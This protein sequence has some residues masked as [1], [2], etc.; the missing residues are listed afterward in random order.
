MLNF[1]YTFLCNSLYSNTQITPKTLNN[2]KIIINTNN[3]YYIDNPIQQSTSRYIIIIDIINTLYNK[4]TQH[5]HNI[6]PFYAIKCNPDYELLKRLVS[7]NVSFDCASK[8]EI[9]VII[10]IFNILNIDITKRN[11]RMIYANPIKRESDIQYALENGV[12]KLTVDCLSELQKINKIDID[13]KA[14]LFIRI[15]VCDNYSKIKL[16]KKFGIIISSNFTEIIELFEFI[17]NNNMNLYG[18]SF[19]VGSSCNNINAYINAF[20]ITTNIINKY[21]ELY[22]KQIKCIDIGGGFLGSDSTTYNFSDISSGI[23]TLISVLTSKYPHIQF[24]AEPGRFFAEQTTIL[25]AN[26]IGKKIENNIYIYY[27][28]ESTYMGFNCIHNDHCSV[29]DI[30]FIID[31][32]FISAD[33]IPTTSL[34]KTQL[35]GCTCDSIDII[36]ITTKYSKDDFLMF[37]ELNINDKLIIDKFGAY[38]YSAGVEFNG[39]STPIK[40]Y[41]N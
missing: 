21:T 25:V 33:N 41:I 28:D 22:N 34:Y 23:T 8:T 37:P 15:K 20:N 36:N 10:S 18:L 9:S 5:M 38:T 2:N 19:H 12:Y 40:Y 29:F 16:N 6:Q 31:T 24:I 26:I 1:I 32:Q 35:N 13:K 17:N 39:I 4:W 7:L 11:E 14:E 27:I 3:L 30:N